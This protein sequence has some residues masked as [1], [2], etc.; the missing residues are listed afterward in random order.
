MTKGDLIYCHTCERITIDIN[1]LST[2]DGRLNP[3]WNY[4]CGWCHGFKT[5]N[6]SQYLDSKQHEQKIILAVGKNEHTLRARGR[7]LVAARIIKSFTVQPVARGK[8]K[9]Y[10]RRRI[11]QKLGKAVREWERIA[12]ERT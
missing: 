1:T 5:I 8:F 11:R 7:A 12:L 3:K 6:A 2:Q 10:E 4:R 9:L